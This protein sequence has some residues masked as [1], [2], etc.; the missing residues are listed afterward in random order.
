MAASEGVFNME[1]C[2]FMKEYEVMKNEVGNIVAH[3]PVCNKQTKMFKKMAS[4]EP[5]KIW[6]AEV[7]MKLIDQMIHHAQKKVASW[8]RSICLCLCGACVRQLV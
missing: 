6:S 8:Y 7:E 3:C 5:L 2:M 4:F 1:F